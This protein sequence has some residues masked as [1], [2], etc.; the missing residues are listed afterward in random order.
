MKIVKRNVEDVGSCSFHVGFKLDGSFLDY[1][2]DEVYEVSSGNNGGQVVRF[3]KV[4]LGKLLSE[5]I[6]EELK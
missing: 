3:C 1:D 6:I 2:H 5:T 4:C